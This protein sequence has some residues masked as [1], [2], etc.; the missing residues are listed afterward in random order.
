MK[1]RFGQSIGHP[2]QILTFLFQGEKQSILYIFLVNLPFEALVTNQ[3]IN[4]L[5]ISMYLKQIFI[6]DLLCPNTSKLCGFSGESD[7]VPVLILER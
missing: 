3:S 7:K 2:F 6:E 4:H 5:S 1:C